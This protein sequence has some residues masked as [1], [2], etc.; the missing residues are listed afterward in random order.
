MIVGMVTPSSLRIVLVGR[1]LIPLGGFGFVGNGWDIRPSD[2][3]QHSPCQYLDQV[4]G[5][6]PD[7]GIRLDE[8]GHLTTGGAS[9]RPFVVEGGEV[10]ADP[11]G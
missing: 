2:G 6:E 7:V 3:Q 11:D 1:R 4:L 10:V 5:Q 9:R 8:R